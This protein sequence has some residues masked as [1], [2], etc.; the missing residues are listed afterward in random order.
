MLCEDLGYFKT[1]E[2]YKA[3]ELCDRVGMM[4]NR[5]LKKLG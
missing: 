3:L 2:N 1:N 4:L 5:L